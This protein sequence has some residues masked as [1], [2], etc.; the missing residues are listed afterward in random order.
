MS[1]YQN[2]SKS[3]PTRVYN[4][5]RYYLLFEF[6]VTCIDVLSTYKTA[7]YVCILIEASDYITNKNLLLPQ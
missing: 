2:N 3:V 4:L 6:Y 5:L 1:T 7:A